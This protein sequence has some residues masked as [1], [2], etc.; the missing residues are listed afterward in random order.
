MRLSLISVLSLVTVFLA[1]G[2]ALPSPTSPSDVGGIG[3]VDEV[4]EIAGEV[5]TSPDGSQYLK[6]SEGFNT[7]HP[8]L[9]LPHLLELYQ[10]GQPLPTLPGVPAAP[11][12]HPGENRFMNWAP[13]PELK[14]QTSGGS[15][16]QSDVLALAQDLINIGKGGAWC[17]HKALGK[18]CST[19]MWRNSAASDLCHWDHKKVCTPCLKVGNAVKEIGTK[20]GKAG[21]AGGRKRYVP[22]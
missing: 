21:K 3:G 8:A 12:E 15:P 11:T 5:L 2:S 7:S 17:C 22:P 4:D 19:M 10:A 9:D 16:E 13:N 20:C 14:C 1:G 18:T 6:L